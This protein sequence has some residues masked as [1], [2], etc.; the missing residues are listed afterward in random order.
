M[1][2]IF[3]L[4]HLKYS[5]DKSIEET[6]VNHDSSGFGFVPSTMACG[7]RMPQPSAC[8]S[9]PTPL[10]MMHAPGLIWILQVHK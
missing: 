1:Y 7:M 5:R 10:A 8:M 2:N 9:I 4:S 3:L 6:G